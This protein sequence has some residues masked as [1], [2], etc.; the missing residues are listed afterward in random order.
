MP[1]G[2]RADTAM[3]EDFGHLVPELIRELDARR[4]AGACP[5]NIPATVL[6][7]LIAGRLPADRAEQ[8]R[9]HLAACL[10]CL[11]TYAELQSLSDLPTPS[12]ARQQALESLHPAVPPR[13]AQIQQQLTNLLWQLQTAMVAFRPATARTSYKTSYKRL[14]FARTTFADTLCRLKIEPE[15]QPYSREDAERDLDQ[16][17]PRNDEQARALGVLRSLL[18][19][20]DAIAAE[21]LAA[22]LPKPL[23]SDLLRQQQSVAGD[24]LRGIRPVTAKPVGRAAAKKK[25]AKKA[26]KKK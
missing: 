3:T 16:V 24:L 26:A 20:L 14:G 25:M 17:H 13:I 18:E 21:I 19:R 12:E 5:S 9:Q 2:R 8:V 7:E 1:R 22:D 15:R 6:D 23:K 10:V 11:N 4:E